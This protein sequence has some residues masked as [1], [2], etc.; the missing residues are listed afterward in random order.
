[1]TEDEGKGSPL[2]IGY[3]EECL[4]REPTYT[5]SG[6]TEV[7]NTPFRRRLHL[8]KLWRQLDTLSPRGNKEIF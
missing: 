3:V 4:L 2:A 5:I 6:G 7:G 1:M 8:P